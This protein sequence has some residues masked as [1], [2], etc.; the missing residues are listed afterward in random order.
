MVHLIT[1]T[2]ITEQTNWILVNSE[3]NISD[4]ELEVVGNKHYEYSLN[5][6]EM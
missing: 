1:E 5:K 2:G 6:I 3:A 4:K